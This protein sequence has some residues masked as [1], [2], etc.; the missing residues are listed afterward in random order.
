[1]KIS[2]QQAEPGFRP[3]LRRHPGH[4]RLP[5]YRLT[6]EDR[7]ILARARPAFD[8]AREISGSTQRR[9]GVDEHGNFTGP[10]ADEILAEHGVR[11]SPGNARYYA[12][13]RKLM[14]AA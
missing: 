12:L 8:A 14:E 1:M 7:R 6:A 3:T 2:N 13:V 9:A 11:W 4:P 10:T 5:H